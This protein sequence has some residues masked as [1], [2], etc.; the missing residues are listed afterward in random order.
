[1][2]AWVV[3]PNDGDPDAL[4]IRDSLQEG[5]L[6]RQA[7]REGV[8]NRVLAEDLDCYTGINRLVAAR[9]ESDMDANHRAIRERA[10]VF[11]DSDHVIL[12][13]YYLLPTSS[14]SPLDVEEEGALPPFEA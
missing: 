8:R 9:V 12:L 10:A 7:R 11:D 6:D 13:S 4:G 5:V 1:M 14:S 2:P 3:D